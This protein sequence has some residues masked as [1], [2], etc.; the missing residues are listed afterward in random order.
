MQLKRKSSS[1]L[2]ILSVLVFMTLTQSAFGQVKA[3]AGQGGICP[4]PSTPGTPVVSNVGSSSVRL[5][6]S[7][8]TNA[9]SYTVLYTINGG[10][11]R[12]AFADNGVATVGGLDAGSTCTFRIEADKNCLDVDGNPFTHSSFSGS[13]REGQ[14]IRRIIGVLHILRCD[15]N[16]TRHT[17]HGCSHRCNHHGFHCK[18]AFD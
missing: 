8:S 18:L 16:S 10:D 15:A 7:L 9:D 12:A 4:F 17:N 5:T 11:E 3:F 6:W 13:A 1:S 14:H 2:A